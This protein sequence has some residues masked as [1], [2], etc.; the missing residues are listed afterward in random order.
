MKAHF[1]VPSCFWELSLSFMLL[2]S[3]SGDRF[4]IVAD[5]ISKIMDSLRAF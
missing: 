2:P 3:F 5:C 4:C 1:P